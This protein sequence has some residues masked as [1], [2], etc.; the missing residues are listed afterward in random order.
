MVFSV[1]NVHDWRIRVSLIY[2]PN[3]TH[4]YATMMDLKTNR[5]CMAIVLMLQ[6]FGM[7]Q[8]R[9][10][11]TGNSQFKEEAARQAE[12]YQSRGQDVP[13]GYMTDRSLLAYAQCLPS[14][15]SLSLTNLGTADRW[16]DIGA[17]EGRAVLDYFTSKYDAMLFEG[18]ERHDKKAQA[19]AISIED[20]R[21]AQWH[22]TAA[23]LQADRIRYLSG[24]RLGAYSFEELGRFQ[25]I[26]DVL[27]GFSYT[28]SLSS[29]MEKALSLLEVNGSFYTL[30]QDVQSEDGSNRPYYPEARYLTEINAA[31]GSEVKV[32]SWLKKIGCVEVSCELKADYVPPIEVYRIR[33]VCAN[34]TVPTLVPVH[35]EA[36]TPPER[37]FQLRSAAP[38]RSS[39]T[40]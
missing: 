36:G 34:V 26:T 30:L 6:I 33:K 24:K 9:S 15:F 32:C 40:R 13:S 2:F 38:S 37:R 4:P 11:S 5:L 17:G 27:G 18:R 7:G 22:R 14:E 21:T 3:S 12:I 8:A 16:L 35:F 20:R 19:I 29:F 28:D 25:V 23:S 31:D 39:E 1:R 10:D